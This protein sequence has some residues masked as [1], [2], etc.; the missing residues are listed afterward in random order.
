MEPSKQ[1]E[2]MKTYQTMISLDHDLTSI[3]RDFSDP[4]DL[5][6]SAQI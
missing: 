3:L 1:T 4:L 5:S 2:A 6:Y